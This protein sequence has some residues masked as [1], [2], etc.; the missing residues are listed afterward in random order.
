MVRLFFFATVVTVLTTFMS[1]E[2]HRMIFAATGGLLLIN[3]FVLS[4][5][6]YVSEIRR[7]LR[8]SPP[9]TSKDESLHQTL[10]DPS[11]PNHP[12]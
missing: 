7:R 9:V 3:I 5:K 1:S 8:F 11:F 4:R 2:S 6:S 10:Y 12:E